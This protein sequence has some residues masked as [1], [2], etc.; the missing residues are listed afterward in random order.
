MCQ[1]KIREDIKNHQ[2]VQNLIVGLINRQTEPYDQNSIYQLAEHY[3][4][5]SPTEISPSALRKM[6]D[7]NLSFLYRKTLVDC[8]CGHYFPRSVFDN[9][10]D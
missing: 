2:D 4:Q 8:R 1:V 10:I 5:G 9:M 3:L 6:I 7:E